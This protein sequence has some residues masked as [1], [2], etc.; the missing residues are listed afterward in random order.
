[1]VKV[2]K[3]TQLNNWDL[4]GN[5]QGLILIRE[6][7]FTTTSSPTVKKLNAFFSSK[8]GPFRP[9]FA[10]KLDQGSKERKMKAN[11]DATD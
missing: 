8:F 5:F 2:G 6:S 4:L 9:Y 3:N 1:M 11:L 7:F 10:F